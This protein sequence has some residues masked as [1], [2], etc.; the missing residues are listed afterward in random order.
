VSPS[1]SNDVVPAPVETTM[2]S[3]KTPGY[4]TRSSL[5]YVIESSTFWLGKPARLTRHCS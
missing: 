1:F 5:A 4:C 3:T 2:S